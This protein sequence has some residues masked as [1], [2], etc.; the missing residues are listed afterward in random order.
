M[1]LWLGGYLGRFVL[2]LHIPMLLRGG[3]VQVRRLTATALSVSKV[4]ISCDPV[5]DYLRT[6]MKGPMNG[7]ALQ[8]NGNSRSTYGGWVNHVLCILHRRHI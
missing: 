8:M 1:T 7:L 2:P 3:V 4:Q 6:T 5:I